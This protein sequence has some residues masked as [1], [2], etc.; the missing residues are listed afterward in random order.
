MLSDKYNLEI[1]YKLWYWHTTTPAS[2]IHRIDVSI[3]VPVGVLI[4]LHKFTE[5]KIFETKIKI[6]Y[7]KIEENLEFTN[8]AWPMGNLRDHT[9]L[10]LCPQ[11]FSKIATC[12]LPLCHHVAQRSARRLGRASHSCRLEVPPASGKLIRFSPRKKTP[13]LW[14][15]WRRNYFVQLEP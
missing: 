12:R 9:L 11:L 15:R 2:I 1:I 3:R 6:I 14:R 7:V 5:I 8:W 13:M 4:C 10:F